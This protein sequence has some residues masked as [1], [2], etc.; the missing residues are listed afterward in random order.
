MRYELNNINYDIDRALVA[1][2]GTII[3]TVNSRLL[4]AGVSRTPAH[5]VLDTAQSLWC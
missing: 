3:S 5:S 4:A 2:S 1:I